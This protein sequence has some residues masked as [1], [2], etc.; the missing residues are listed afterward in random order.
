MMKQMIRCKA[1]VEWHEMEGMPTV[2]LVPND[3]DREGNAANLGKLGHP[4][5]VDIYCAKH[6]AIILETRVELGPGGPVA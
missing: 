6:D 2:K 3:E 1:C 4:R 5:D